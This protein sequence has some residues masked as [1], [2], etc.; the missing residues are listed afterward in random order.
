MWLVKIWFN[1]KHTETMLC[2]W[3]TLSGQFLGATILIGENFVVALPHLARF[4]AFA[5]WARFSGFLRVNGA[6]SFR[7]SRL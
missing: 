5:T 3:R 7:E 1:I 2:A 6:K 4:A